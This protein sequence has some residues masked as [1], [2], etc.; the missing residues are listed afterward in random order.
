MSDGHGCDAGA[1]HCGPD[2]AVAASASGDAGY[3]VGPDGRTP[4]PNIKRLTINGAPVTE[5]SHEY[6]MRSSSSPFINHRA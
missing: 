1:S 2:G 4:R 5:S 6:V 3:A